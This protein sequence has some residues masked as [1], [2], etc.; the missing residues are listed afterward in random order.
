MRAGPDGIREMED[1]TAK[2]RELALHWQVFLYWQNFI[3]R[4]CKEFLSG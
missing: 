1:V 4:T 2:M 3:G